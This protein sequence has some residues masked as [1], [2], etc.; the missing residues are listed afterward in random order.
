MTWSRRENIWQPFPLPFTR[1]H[2]PPGQG[3]YDDS[4]GPVDCGLIVRESASPEEAPDSYWQLTAP[5]ATW[6]TWTAGFYWESS[7]YISNRHPADCLHIGIDLGPLESGQSR[8]VRGKFYWLEGTKEDV[9]T[10]WQKD[11][12]ESITKRA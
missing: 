12:G 4:S 3:I 2:L 6:E 8:T 7:A 10:L 9:L 5:E 11:F 1:Y